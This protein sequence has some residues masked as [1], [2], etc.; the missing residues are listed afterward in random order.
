[1][2]AF[3]KGLELEPTNKTFADMAAKAKA[4]AAKVRVRM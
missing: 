4:A 2:A 1:M 3:E